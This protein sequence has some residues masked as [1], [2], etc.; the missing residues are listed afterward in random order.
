MPDDGSTR[1]ARRFLHVCYCCE[2]TEP[3]VKFFVDALAMRNTMTVPTEWST[4]AIL[5]LE[6]EVLGGAAFL[7]DAR[8]PR[9]SPAI[10]AQNWV[11][12]KRVGTPVDDPTAVGV[13]ALGFA[14]PDLATAGERLVSRGCKIIGSGR[15]PFG[16]AWATLRD[17]TGV[18]LD[19]VEDP[20][21]P[22]EETR[23][24]HLRITCS[25]LSASLA[26]YEGLGFEV[27]EKA[28]IDDGAFLGL[29]D[30]VRAE[31]AR[32]RLP[33]EPFEAVLVQWHEPRSHGRH[34]AEPNHAGLFRTAVGV[35][36]T[37]ASYEAMSAAGWTFDRAPMSVE[38][39]GTPVPD[40][41]ICFLSD[42]DGVP[43]EFV[44]RPRAA[45][46]S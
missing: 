20:S 11:D 1:P 42:P 36:D 28:A 2:D 25:D 32:L 17:V 7:Y 13:Q 15:S 14:V 21:V 37:R 45:F 18:T 31:S 12:P 3:V 35:D 41:W 39:K 26:W 46:R 29:A 43:F 19:L 33:D 24:H 6:G 23:M 30:P 9:I 22:V 27:V 44:G 38:L 34:Y 8:G 10:E 40:M 4:G 16:F 5:G